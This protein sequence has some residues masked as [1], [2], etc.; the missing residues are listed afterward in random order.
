MREIIQNRIFVKHEAKIFDNK[1][2]YKSRS[3]GKVSE[4]TIPYEDLLRYK[5]SH[6]IITPYI[7]AIILV[8]AFITVVCFAYRN[9]E[10]FESHA[11]VFWGCFL[12][13]ASVFYLIN[14]Q[15]L[16]KVKVSNNTYL[17][18][19]KSSPSAIVVDEFINDLFNTRDKYLNETYF[20]NFNKNLS[21]ESQRNNLDWLYRV[22]AINKEKYENAKRELDTVF[23][24]DLK[25]IG[26]N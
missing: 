24:I 15:N 3:F 16:W 14:K 17:F 22:E 26:F 12:I 20:G 25:K 8:L 2:V 1:I 11:W 23:N 4:V 5:E 19:F 7:R 21:Y 18:F 13:I 9:D 6:V 10:N